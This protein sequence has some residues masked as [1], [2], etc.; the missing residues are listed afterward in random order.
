MTAREGAALEFEVTPANV[1]DGK[2]FPKL[3]QDLGNDD[4]LA[5]IKEVFGDNAYASDA[6]E[7]LVKSDGKVPQF[8][9]KDETG[10]HPRHPRQARRKSRTRSKIEADIGILST[11]YTIQHVRVR[12]LGRVRVECALALALWNLLILLAH[13]EGRFEDRLSVRQLFS[14]QNPQLGGA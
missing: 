1:H 5:W 12:G 3:W 8:H 10:K 9:S 6:N 13:I 11:N 4:L 2:T 14:R 7:T